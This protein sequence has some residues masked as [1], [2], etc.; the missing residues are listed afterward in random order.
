MRRAGPSPR[1]LRVA[2][3]A[4]LLAAP[5]AAGDL[6]LTSR[7][8]DQ[9][10]RYDGTTGT[11]VAVF[12]AG[13][14]LVNPVGLTFGPD[15]H[16]YVASAGTDRVLRYDG[17]SGAFLG[18]FA[19]AGELD[20]PRQIQFGPRGDLFV[21]SAGTNQIL[22]FDGASGAFLGVFTG[23]SNLD[24]PN[25]ITFG[26]G[27]HLYVAGVLND[28]VKYYDGETGQAL[29][30]FA[31]DNLDLPHDVSFG[32]DGR[33]YV[34]NAGSTRIGRYD[35]QSG[36]YVDDFV[37]DPALSAA[38][39]ML[40]FPDGDLLVV[41]QGSDEARRY[42]GESGALDS[43]F[44]LPGAGGVDG[45]LYAATMPDPGPVLELS[46]GLSNA[47]NHLIVRGAAPG[48]QLWIAAGTLPGVRPLPGCGGAAL[49]IGDARLVGEGWADE[50]GRLVLRRRLPP[51][52]AGLT[53]LIQAADPARCSLS[54]MVTV[55]IQ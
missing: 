33:L 8:T 12:A 7:F 24:G 45:P 9:V 18:V 26:T 40:W 51:E 38:L 34:T 42:D 53:F 48:A 31:K 1:G 27:G 30:N 6:L 46:P 29:G 49:G 37:D 11:F 20:E 21:A 43:V 16:L 41:N 15:G 52:T 50:G 47:P 55:T 14:E 4:M 28:R 25:G 39:G 22:R 13:S 44:V 32:P 54:P 19:E 3:L 5:T 10:L 17:T 2:S 35:G 23:A 36:E